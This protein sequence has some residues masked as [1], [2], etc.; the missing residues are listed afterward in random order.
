VSSEVVAAILGALAAGLLQTIVSI[1]DRRRETESTLVAIASEIDSI[2]RLIRFRQYPHY[3]NSV[4]AASAAPDWPITTVVIDIRS[5]YFSVFEALSHNL[6]RL[7]PSQAAKIVNF[8]AYCKST[9][10][11]ALPDGVMVENDDRELAIENLGQIKLLLDT[12]LCLGDEI[13]QFPK[14]SLVDLRGKDD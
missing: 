10:D 6:G 9:I 7:K 12:V 11:S 5:N 14:V 8:Y 2:C 4:L 3:V 1:I 13:V